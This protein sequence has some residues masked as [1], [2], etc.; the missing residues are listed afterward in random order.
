M[1]LTDRA[2]SITFL[3]R[4][5]DSRFSRAFDAVF[6][7]DGIQDPHQ[8]P[9]APRANAIWSA[10]SVLVCMRESAVSDPVVPMAPLG[11]RLAIRWLTSRCQIS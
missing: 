1:D 5:H 10:A 11:R 2:T 4:D 3:L 6:A 8:S 7:A 9:G